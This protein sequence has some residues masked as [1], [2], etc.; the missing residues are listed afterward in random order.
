M[1]DATAGLYASEALQAVTGETVRPGGYDLT[2]RAVEFCGLATGSRLLDV[3]CGTGASVELLIGEYRLDA[4]GVDPTGK[5]LE[6]GRRRVC[7]IADISGQRGSVGIRG[8]SILRCDFDRVQSV[9]MCRYPT[10]TPRVQPGFGARR[11]VDRQRPVYP[12]KQRTGRRIATKRAY[13]DGCDTSP[14]R[15]ARV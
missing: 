7:H 4:V 2:R 10:G 9:A 8:G 11:M 13:G 15:I 14:V 1:S 12:A 3:G 6:L 5:M